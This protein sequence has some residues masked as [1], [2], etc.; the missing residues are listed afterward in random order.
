VTKRS[1]LDAVHRL[2]RLI[3]AAAAGRA[4]APEDAQLLHAFLAEL[5]RTGRCQLVLLGLVGKWR[6]DSLREPGK[7]LVCTM[8][9]TGMGGAAIW[10]ALMLDRQL[11]PAKSIP[12][13]RTI[14]RWVRASE[15]DPD[16]SHE[17]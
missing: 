1:C 8:A 4:P 12:S 5:G 2:D 17:I 6:E 13:H 14:M 9:Q 3:A 15:N 11:Y 16:A 10:R 7:V